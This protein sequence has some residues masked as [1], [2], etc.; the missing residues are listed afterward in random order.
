MFLI[1]LFLFIT[2]IC[3]TYST[4]Q[5]IIIVLGSHDNNI[6]NERVYSTIDYIN[7]SD[8]PSIIYLSGGVKDGLKKDYTDSDSE[9]FKMNKIFSSNFDIEIVQD[10]LAKNTAENFA[11]LKHWVYNNFD[12]I[13]NIVISTSD[14]HKKRAELIFNGIFPEVDP[15]W[16]L[17]ISKCHQCWKDEHIHIKNVK[18]DILKTQ[19]NLSIKN[20]KNDVFKIHKEVSSKDL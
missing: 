2:N 10:Q 20:I 8:N 12:Y 19:L 4:I 18:S 14:F 1:C 11:Y 15:I 3:N 17:S 6:L 5:N 13:P 9:A 7:N 16:N